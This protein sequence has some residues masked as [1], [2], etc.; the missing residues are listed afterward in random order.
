MLIKIKT[1]RKTTVVSG[2]VNIF[3]FPVTIIAIFVLSII[4]LG[5]V[6]IPMGILYVSFM[7]IS[8]MLSTFIVGSIMSEYIINK[9]SNK[10]GEKWYKLLLAFFVF[11]GLSTI[12][13]IPKVGSTLA[14]ALCILSVGIVY[15]TIFKKIKE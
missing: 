5:I 15:T 10:I 7:A 13:E 12:V 3:L 4:G 11:F 2:F 9:Y 8:F 6:T 14:V 1:Y